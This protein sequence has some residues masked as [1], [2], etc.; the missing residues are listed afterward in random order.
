[1]TSG[2]RRREF[3]AGLGAGLGEV[4]SSSLIV[5]G[6]NVIKRTSASITTDLQN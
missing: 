6:R 4:A 2:I 1:M 3:V 5:E